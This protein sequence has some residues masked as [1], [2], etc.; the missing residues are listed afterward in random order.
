MIYLILSTILKYYFYKNN[1]YLYI[2]KNNINDI[3][4]S[5]KIKIEYLPFALLNKNKKDKFIAGEYIYI[6]KKMF[7]DADYYNQY[8]YNNCYPKIKVSNDRFNEMQNQFIILHEIGHHFLNKNDMKQN[9]YLADMYISEFF[10]NTPKFLKFIYNKQ[11]NH[12]NKYK[13]INNFKAN[14]LFLFHY[15]KFLLKNKK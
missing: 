11:L 1:S 2:I 9:E 12:Y 8:V 10:D 5:E 4:K 6:T 3:L 13:K 7:D 14:F 15:V